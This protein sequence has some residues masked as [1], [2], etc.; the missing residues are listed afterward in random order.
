MISPA[1]ARPWTRFAIS[2][3]ASSLLVLASTLSLV[4]AAAAQDAPQ[5][6][7]W[8][9]LAEAQG[10][11]NAAPGPRQVPGRVIPVPGTVSEA[12]QGLIAAPYSPF[13]NA[14]GTTA[15]EWRAIASGADATAEPMLAELRAALEVGLEETTIAGVRCFVLT[16][17]SIPDAHRDQVILNLHGGGYIYGS[18]V[19]GT[20]EATMMAAYGGY[21]VI[22]VDYRMPPDAPYPAAVDDAAAVYRALI[23]DEGM[24]PA[25]VAVGGTSTGGGLAL[26]LMLRIKAEGLPMPGALAPNSPWSD[27]T[28]AGDS[29]QAN[30]WIDNVV[31]SYDGYLDEA[32]RLYAGG[33]DLAEPELSPVYGDL[34]GLPPT[35]LVAGTRDLFLSNTVRIQRRLRQAGVTVDLQLFDGLSH[36]QYLFDPTAPETVE[37]FGEI[38]RFL[39]EHLAG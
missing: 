24:D 10:A 25:R 31:V 6:A 11:A 39:D 3:V 22:A 16:P 1:M 9:E 26:A 8:A 17:Q 18:G 28:G 35:I 38:T 13:W 4:G 32:A 23:E 7:G 27:L 14:A 12:A 34:A 20:A 19:S 2:A 36:A 21:R 30:E 15:A 29:Y 37:M 5:D 33:R